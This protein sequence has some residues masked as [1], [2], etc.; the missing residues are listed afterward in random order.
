VLEQDIQAEE[1]VGCRR[2]HQ[3]APMRARAISAS[4]QRR[5]SVVM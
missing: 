2:L 1:T 3:G 5:S 4:S